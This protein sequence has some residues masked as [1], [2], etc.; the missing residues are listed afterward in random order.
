MPE[1]TI[2]EEG[3]FLIGTNANVFNQKIFEY[4]QAFY[5]YKWIAADS[6][7]GEVS[8][9]PRSDAAMNIVYQA[10]SKDLGY[11][12]E[13]YYPF[14][15][16]DG[17]ISKYKNKKLPPSLERIVDQAVNIFCTHEPSYCYLRNISRKQK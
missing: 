2:D 8:K 9:T 10:M 17:A 16:S 4:Y 12:A 15:N 14:K 6:A 7:L 13:N 11:D 1:G 3:F 5:K